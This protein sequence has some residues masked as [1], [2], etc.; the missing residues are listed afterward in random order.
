MKIIQ[1]KSIHIRSFLFLFFFYM[2]TLSF[3]Y[4]VIPQST[5]SLYQHLLAINGEWATQG[6]ETTIDLKQNYS[7]SSHK[8]RIQTHLKL[9]EQHLRQKKVSHLSIK[10]QQNRI[11]QLDVLRQYWQRGLFPKNTFHSQ[12]TPYFV[13]IYETACAVGYLVLESGEKD[14]VQQIQQKN[15]YAY[16]RD[17]PYD[18]LHVWADNNGFS[19]DELAWIQPIYSSNSFHGLGNSGGVNGTV[20]VLVNHNDE[21][22]YIGG[23]FDAVDGQVANSIIAWNG[24]TW[25]TLGE[26]VEGEILA[27]DIY[28]NQVYIAGNFTLPNEEDTSNIAVWD[29]SAWQGLQSGDMEGQIYDIIFY[30]GDLVIG[31]DFQKVNNMNMPY[32]ARYDLSAQTWSNAAF[33]YDT[34]I[35][36]Y[37][38]IPDAFSVD[39]TVRCF[40]MVEEYLLVGGDFNLTAPMVEDGSI[41]K[42]E[43][44][45]L[46]YWEGGFFE[47]NWKTALQGEHGPA[48]AVH[49][50]NGYLYVGGAVENN[51]NIATLSAGI[52]NYPF[53]DWLNIAPMGDGRIH[54]FIEN[55]EG[56]LMYGGFNENEYFLGIRNIYDGEFDLI[57]VPGFFADNTVKAAVLFQNKLHVGGDF[58]TINGSDPINGLGFLEVVSDVNETQ[59][60]SNMNVYYQQQ[61]LHFEY[62]GLETVANWAMYN[63]QGQLILSG[64]LLAGQ[65][66]VASAL[67]DLANGI[68]F[69][70]IVNQNGRK[71]GKVLIHR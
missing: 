38:E 52:W 64:D 63:G 10:Q 30:Q 67:P 6:L 50:Q 42:L 62:E 7:F 29:G 3:A 56:T 66:H 54:G 60:L 39:N 36:D 22:L 51:Q 14:L 59:T 25:A 47:E 35:S 70:E 24:D 19:I 48:Y 26:G 2:T 9:V 11:T 5:T 65:Q 71:S 32:L 13:D 12:A 15:N 44:Q 1:L 49:Y 8:H 33:R 23:Q 53:E 4:P 18:A 28:N 69:Y 34:N 20:N 40:E 58:I 17:M 21:R 43:A 61:Q 45:Y 27:M 31:G 68:Y 57:N 55:E 46:A 41:L 37:V 16:I